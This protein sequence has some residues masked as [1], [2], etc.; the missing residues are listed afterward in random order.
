MRAFHSFLHFFKIGSLALFLCAFGESARGMDVAPPPPPVA[1][2]LETDALRAARENV[3][4]VGSDQWYWEEKG[5]SINFYT[6]LQTQTLDGG[7]VDIDFKP[8]QAIASCT[9]TNCQIKFKT[10]DNWV[11]YKD[12]TITDQIK[13]KGLSFANPTPDD[14]L[15][16]LQPLTDTATGETFFIAQEEGTRIFYL[17]KT[18]PQKVNPKMGSYGFVY[19]HTLDNVAAVGILREDG[20][21]TIDFYLSYLIPKQEFA[22]QV[23][24]GG[25]WNTSKTLE[26]EMGKPAS[27]KEAHRI[28]PDEWIVKIK[29]TVP[30]LSLPTDE[31][32]VDFSENFFFKA[33]TLE[34]S[35]K[36]TKE[37][38]NLCFSLGQVFEVEDQGKCKRFP[39]GNIIGTFVDTTVF[40]LAKSP[41]EAF[42]GDGITTEKVRTPLGQT[43]YLKSDFTR[44]MFS[45]EFM[46]AAPDDTVR[47]IPSQAYYVPTERVLI[48]NFDKIFEFFSRNPK[49]NVTQI[50]A[51]LKSSLDYSIER[52]TL[53]SPQTLSQIFRK[54][55]P[56]DLDFLAP[57]AVTNQF[58]KTLGRLGYS[59]GGGSGAGFEEDT[60]DGGAIFANFGGKLSQLVIDSDGSISTEVSF[61]A[62][63]E[64]VDATR[65]ALS[66][67]DNP[68]IIATSWLLDIFKQS[69][70]FIETKNSETKTATGK[71]LTSDMKAKLFAQNNKV[72]FD[73]MKTTSGQIPILKEEDLPLV[74]SAMEAYNLMLDSLSA[75]PRRIVYSALSARFTTPSNCTKEEFKSYTISNDE[76][77][78]SLGKD[79]TESVLMPS[80]ALTLQPDIE[81]PTSSLFALLVSPQ[82]QEVMFEGD[83]K[84]KIYIDQVILTFE[85]YQSLEVGKYKEALIAARSTAQSNQT[86]VSKAGLVA[87]D[88]LIDLDLGV[89][90][91][92]RGLATTYQ[93]QKAAFLSAPTEID[94]TFVVSV[95]PELSDPAMQ[96]HMEKKLRLEDT[97]LF[98]N[99]QKRVLEEKT[100]FSTDKGKEVPIK[101]YLEFLKNLDE[102]F[103]YQ[104]AKLLN[105]ALDKSLKLST[106]LQTIKQKKEKLA[107]TYD[108]AVEETLEK[109]RAFLATYFKDD[110]SRV[111][112][113]MQTEG[114][115]E[116]DEHLLLKS[117]NTELSS[118]LKGETALK[119]FQLLEDGEPVNEQLALPTTASIEIILKAV[120]S[121]TIDQLLGLFLK[122]QGNDYLEYFVLQSLYNKV[123][124][125]KEA[126]KEKVL[127]FIFP[128]IR[129]SKSMFWKWV[130]ANQSGSPKNNYLNLVNLNS[131]Q[132][133]DYFKAKLFYEWGEILFKDGKNFETWL[134]A[135]AP[136]KEGY[137]DNLKMTLKVSDDS[138]DSWLANTKQ[139][140]LAFFKAVDYLKT[141]EIAANTM[142]AKEE[143][144][145]IFI[146]THPLPVTQQ[147]TQTIQLM[148]ILQTLKQTLNTAVANTLVP[149]GQSDVFF[150]AI[151]MKRF[152]SIDFSKFR[153][154]GKTKQEDRAIVQVSSPTVAAVGVSNSP[155][156]ESVP[157]S[158]KGRWKSSEANAPVEKTA[159]SARRKL[160][161]GDRLTRDDENALADDTEGELIALL[162]QDPH[163]LS[164]SQARTCIAL[165]KRKRIAAKSGGMGGGMG[166]TTADT[167]FCTQEIM[168][169]IKK[170]L[171]QLLA[172]SEGAR[173]GSDFPLSSA[174]IAASSSMGGGSFGSGFGLSDGLID[175][176]VI[177]EKKDRGGKKVARYEVKK[178]NISSKI[179]TKQDLVFDD[180][181]KLAWN[182]KNLGYSYGQFSQSLTS[183]Q[184]E[185]TILEAASPS[186]SEADGDGE[187][188][189]KGLHLSYLQGQLDEL[190]R[191]IDLKKLQIDLL[192]AKKAD[193]ERQKIEAIEVEQ[194]AFLSSIMIEDDDQDLTG[195]IDGKIAEFGQ[196][197]EELSANLALPSAS[198]KFKGQIQMFMSQ[199]Q[200]AQAE[201]NEFMALEIV[202][203]MP[204]ILQ[205]LSALNTET[206]TGLNF[207]LNSGGLERFT[208]AIGF[209]TPTDGLNSTGISTTKE[210][211]TPTEKQKI[212]DFVWIS[213]TSL[214]LELQRIVNGIIKGDD[215]DDKESVKSIIDKLI[216][217][218]N[219]HLGAL[220][221]SFIES[222]R[223][224]IYDLLTAAKSK[225]DTLKLSAFLNIAP[226]RIGET[227][228][229]PQAMLE[230]VGL[231]KQLV[232]SVT[233]V[234]NQPTTI[235]LGT[236]TVTD[237][238][239]GGVLTLGYGIPKPKIIQLSKDHEFATAREFVSKFTTR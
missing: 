81:E 145:N 83:L 17:Y 51:E 208:G 93:A 194:Q 204:R 156:P 57:V 177:V 228:L 237:P 72:L 185:M 174:P 168:A 56:S 165:E 151:W 166:A 201:F 191:K 102:L 19:N 96:W 90:P 235:T 176:I 12:I 146:L 9:K 210:E 43:I 22:P 59:V 35:G 58:L 38:R 37:D 6:Q 112:N 215:D 76:W 218:K 121:A 41:L 85:K 47:F 172:I 138:L 68:A 33:K 73:Q 39:Q 224:K 180:I 187:D 15:N 115:A 66:L 164:D 10:Y 153:V 69:K 126:V 163:N 189:K 170:Q 230:N 139:M 183:I 111:Q 161:T 214:I 159:I 122:V 42:K 123:Y 75:V 11:K 212:K 125:Q 46:D 124:Q 74:T 200:E 199:L 222:A 63:A 140:K 234:K 225:L 87:Y 239:P 129:D 213:K 8:A 231:M 162:T 158:V 117:K 190:T 34:P 77:L 40:A 141:S 188:L 167:S 142:K 209:L 92:F 178:Q 45:K 232:T 127:G 31:R 133:G 106:N 110:L 82:A 227:T 27:F 229:S 24:V 119:V 136:F 50:S 30:F 89:E 192:E 60:G 101:F 91:I 109:Y 7:I 148:S 65:T 195:F 48:A 152:D 131:S 120:S 171:H 193:L 160:Q 130:F 219:N 86:K 202:G 105:T 226:S 44:E 84:E 135:L 3:I 94:E 186:S 28:S 49:E 221:E 95:V 113:E 134:E 238:R 70:D 155:R 197:L 26:G 128:E 184:E 53:F 175:N 144:F 181:S 154:L 18:F 108:R 150:P 64:L 118:V 52:I 216:A 157:S 25:V 116:S 143:A 132:L 97:K 32:E 173:S 147:D 206:Q 78:S 236:R 80:L 13:G 67:K 88:A 198:D 1:E 5:T 36:M 79:L 149:I 196:K 211:Y 14:K 55:A 223:D 205:D 16:A 23:K 103:L 203:L 220:K 62:L 104:D 233:A 20:S 4:N 179:I 29:A 107:K 217:V 98:L 99:I 182:L 100:P 137:I 207:I 114:F 54:H 71:D 2:V 61:R 21:N 169:F